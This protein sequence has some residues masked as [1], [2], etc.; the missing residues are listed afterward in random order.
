MLPFVLLY[1]VISVY[2]P[3]GVC[4]DL[5]VLKNEG[6]VQLECNR[7]FNNI[8]SAVWY[9]TG[10]HG[11]HLDLMNTTKCGSNKVEVAGSGMFACHSTG[12]D[13]CSSA[14]PSKYIV[15]ICEYDF[16]LVIKRNKGTVSDEEMRMTK[17]NRNADQIQMESSG[18][19]SDEGVRMTKVNR[20]ADQIQMESSAQETQRKARKSTPDRPDVLKKSEST[21]ITLSCNFT[22]EGSPFILY[23]I[24][25]AEQTQCLYSYAF[26]DHTFRIQFNEH[27]CVHR[28]PIRRIYNHSDTHASSRIQKHNI[29]IRNATPSDSGHYLCIGARLKVKH[30]QW[31]IVRNI[32]L[33]VEKKNVT[34]VDH[35]G[36][37]LL[38]NMLIA[39]GSVALISGLIV[40]LILLMRHKS[41]GKEDTGS[42]RNTDHPGAPEN[43]ECSPYAVGM[44]D[45]DDSAPEAYYSTVKETHAPEYSLLEASKVTA[46]KPK[47][48]ISTV[49]AL[50]RV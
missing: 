36:N 28:E 2:S 50:A 31:E 16:F 4:G 23:W 49:Y 27:C 14:P 8:Q 22:S 5:Y 34:K 3:S 20:N 46:P 41:K 15:E 47:G 38:K 32:S 40:C 18:A 29:E 21:N 25:T 45:K 48:E 42:C 1:I 10:D 30:H 24:R 43:D 19:V 7:S 33:H 26:E 13:L 11:F 37:E 12:T 9:Q 6:N 17:V 35:E 39:I 44:K